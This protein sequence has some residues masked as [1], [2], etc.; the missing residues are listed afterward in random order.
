ML[1]VAASVK[2]GGAVVEPTTTSYAVRVRYA[3]HTVSW[4]RR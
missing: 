4:Q 1:R 2:T 3:G